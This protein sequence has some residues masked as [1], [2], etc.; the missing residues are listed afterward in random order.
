MKLLT[1]T[2]IP[3]EN[4]IFL[5]KPTRFKKVYIPDQSLCYLNYYH[6]EYALPYQTITTQI[7]AAG[8]KKIYLSRTQFRKKDCIGEEY[9]EQFYR[10]QGYHIVYPEQLDITEQIALISGADEI[11]STIGTISHLALFA[12]EGAK[13]VTLLRARNYFN[14][15][16]AIINQAKGLDYTFVDATCNFLPHRYSANCYYIGPTPMWQ[17][18]VK[19]EYGID[20]N[21]DFFAYLNSDQSHMGDYF[22]QWLKIFSKPRDLKKIQNDTTLNILNTLELATANQDTP[23]QTTVEKLQ[24]DL[25]GNQDL[26]KTLSGKIF[27]FSRQNNSH[28]RVIVLADSGRIETIQGNANDNESFWAIRDNELVFLNINKQLTSRYFYLKETPDGYEGLGY[29]EPNR[30]IIFKLVEAKLA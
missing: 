25:G 23:L 6:Q 8:H 17:R 15:P 22:K 13:I 30:S 9:F 29:Y 7:P 1:Y 19:A 3:R 20:L 24:N 14:I 11:V 28:L 2:G 21:I 12:H 5:D 16:Q 4:I 10:N 27:K 26:R 18:F